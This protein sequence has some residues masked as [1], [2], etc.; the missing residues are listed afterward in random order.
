MYFDS[1][2]EF[3][4]KTE[5]GHIGLLTV[6]TEWKR[7]LITNFLRCITILLNHAFKSG[8]YNEGL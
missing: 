1:G 6:G 5:V 7:K 2:Y 8:R 4:W 3:H